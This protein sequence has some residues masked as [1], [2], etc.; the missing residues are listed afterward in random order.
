MEEE[1]I[2]LPDDTLQRIFMDMTVDQLKEFMMLNSRFFDL[3]RDIMQEK[4]SLRENQRKLAIQKLM[5]ARLRTIP[6]GKVLDLSN[7]NADTGIGMRVMNMP[8]GGRSNKVQIGQYALVV[9]PER[10]DEMVDIMN[11]V[12]MAVVYHK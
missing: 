12:P 4:L 11:T 3:G 9:T 2:S 5:I 7:M 6:A 10:Y 1:E 8:I